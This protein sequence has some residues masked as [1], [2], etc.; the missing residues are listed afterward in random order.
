MYRYQEPPPPPPPSPSQSSNT[1]ALI[2]LIAGIVSVTGMLVSICVGCV[3]IFSFLAGI[4]AAVMG[5]LSKKQIDQVGGRDGDRKM[6]N[7][8]MILGIVGAVL[9]IITILIGLLWVGFTAGLDW[10]LSSH[11]TLV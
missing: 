4:A 2:S 11:L 3:G 10:L 1:L 6:A 7:Y 9:S 5:F 8:G